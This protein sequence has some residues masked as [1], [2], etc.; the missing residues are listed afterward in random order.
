ME[1]IDER[2]DTGNIRIV[3]IEDDM[4]KSTRLDLLLQAGGDVVVTMRDNKKGG[5][6]SVEICSDGGGGRN[7]AIAR[8]LKQLIFKLVEDKKSGKEG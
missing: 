1:I 4:G 2:R 8:V 3:G 7:P 5:R 6:M